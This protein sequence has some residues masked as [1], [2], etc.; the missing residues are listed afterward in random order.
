MMATVFM[1]ATV[2]ILLV[3]VIVDTVATKRASDGAV[4]DARTKAVIQK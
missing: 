2:F 4:D 1:V 3:A